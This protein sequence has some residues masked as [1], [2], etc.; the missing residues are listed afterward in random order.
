M[1]EE[2]CSKCHNATDWAGG[3]AFDT[4][5]PDTIEADAKVWEEA[6]RKLRGGLMP[7]PGEPHPQA[8]VT[9]DFVH[10][11]ET[12]L[13]AHGMEHVDPG[14]VSLHRI[15]RTEYARA[16]ERMLGVKVDPATILPRETKSDGF[17]NVANVLRVSP[18]FLDQY[19]SAARTVSVLAVGEP[20]ARAITQTY[21]APASRQAFYQEGMPLGTRGGMEIE[22]W[23]PADGEY[24]FTLRVPVGGGY[25]AGM[26]EQTLIFKVDGQRVFTQSFGGEVDSRAVDQRQAP[27]TAEIARRFQ[28]IRVPVKAGPRKVTVTFVQESYAEAE[29]TLFP[30]VPGGGNDQHARVAAV[31]IRGPINPT[32]LSDTPSRRLIFSC[33]PKTAVEEPACAKQIIARLTREA[34]RRPV[35]DDD[36][37]APLR[38]F[39]DGR[40]Q[41]DFD[42]GIQTAIMAILSSPKFLYRLEN[43][44]ADL[45]EGKTFPLDDVALASRLAF[46]LWSQGPDDALLGLAV[47]NRLHEPAVLAQQ[48]QRM[49]SD[50]RSRS[51]V[52]NFAW[53][54]LNMDGL[55]DVDPDPA[56]FPA[57][58]DDLRRAYLRE[59]DLF[60]DSVLRQDRPVTELLTAN[61]SFL[62]E[63]LALQYGV[64][65]IRG[66]QFR[67][68]ELTDSKRFGLLGKG[69]ILMLTSYGNRTAPVLR[70]AYILERLTGTPPKA[71]PPGVEALKD[72]QPG[73]KLQTVRERLE[74]HRSKPSCNAC[75]G[76]MDPL[77][78]AL[79][80]FDATGAWRV[81]DRE[82]NLPVDAGAKTP[83]GHVLRGP[84]DL[85]RM[86]A[87]NPGQFVQALTEKLLTY[88]LGR[89]VEFGD[90]PRIRA[91]VREAADKDYRFSALVAGIV[92]S[93]QFRQGKVG[94]ATPPATTST[95]VAAVPRQGEG[96]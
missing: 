20:N 94:P 89:T 2:Y 76:V 44:P 3:V 9:T 17:D 7:P 27:A 58:N 48:V 16:V 82:A 87:D 66:D 37:A 6:V 71:P 96:R 33:R 24:E 54:W 10:W 93:E 64:A 65:N 59:V 14:H 69:A 35:T 32:G 75:H 1:L 12:R 84:D 81:V 60:V 72:N 40:S 52:T 80:N 4:M 70:G 47:A 88:A 91:I 95:T 26:S 51:L 77:G 67:R 85:R 53:Q 79:E 83:D 43:V 38:F 86:L 18:T 8:T 5:S 46:F 21:R 15:N 13:D 25:G 68:V 57:F 50:E 45:P 23:F 55:K 74:L 42:S 11:M 30:F 90:M 41:G 61:Y 36:L 22:H 73:A 62:N 92:N 56:L 19:I 31:D 34:Y 28:K 78:F 39:A 49:L 29:S 63:R